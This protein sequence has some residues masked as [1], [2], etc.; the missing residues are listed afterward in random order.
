MNHDRMNLLKKRIR[1]VE[2]G[3]QGVEPEAKEFQS[4]VGLCL[5]LLASE[6]RD[7][8]EE[9]EALKLQTFKLSRRRAR[10]IQKEVWRGNKNPT[11]F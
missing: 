1:D 5:S 11:Q 4:N 6:V 2:D 3:A 7:L 9:V 10:R 8:R